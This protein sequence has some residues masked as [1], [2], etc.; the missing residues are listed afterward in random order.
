MAQ[1]RITYFSAHVKPQHFIVDEDEVKE[2]VDN[3]KDQQYKVV[4]TDPD[5]PEPTTWER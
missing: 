2:Y 1:K 5:E 4:V 3:G